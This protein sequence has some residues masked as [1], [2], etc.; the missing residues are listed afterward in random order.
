VDVFVFSAGGLLAQAQAHGSR[1]TGHAG[2]WQVDCNPTTLLWAFRNRVLATMVAG[3]PRTRATLLRTCS[4]LALRGVSVGP[5]AIKAA[6]AVAAVPS[7][8]LDR[9]TAL[10]AALFLPI[11]HDSLR[12]QGVMEAC[13]TTADDGCGFL[14]LVAVCAAC[15]TTSVDDMCAVLSRAASEQLKAVVR[16]AARRGGRASSSLTQL[17]VSAFS[18]WRY[19]RNLCRQYSTPSCAARAQSWARLPGCCSPWR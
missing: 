14:A 1:V 17:D 7:P 18:R 4:A 8:E 9:D 16:S 13:M 10:C 12:S 11:G 5:D 2:T 19:P 3:H 6:L 15:A